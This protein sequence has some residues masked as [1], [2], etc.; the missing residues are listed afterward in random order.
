M[1][2]HKISSKIPGLKLASIYKPVTGFILVTYQCLLLAFFF[3]LTLRMHGTFFWVTS[4]PKENLG[5]KLSCK[6]I[7]SVSFCSISARSFYI[8]FYVALSE[9]LWYITLSFNG[10]TR[11]DSFYFFSYLNFSDLLLEREN[12]TKSLLRLSLSVSWFPL[13]VHGLFYSI[14]NKTTERIG[15]QHA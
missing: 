4:G 6:I 7:F 1:Y 15:F 13:V 10:P 2:R 8:Y 3:Y 5:C 12:E 11:F 9:K 14:L